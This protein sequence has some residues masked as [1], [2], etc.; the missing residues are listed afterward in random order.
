MKSVVLIS[1]NTHAFGVLI[2]ATKAFT[3]FNG[4]GEAYIEGAYT[5]PNLYLKETDVACGKYWNLD[6]IGCNKL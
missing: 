6:L 3:A 4:I 2:N 5:S 1:E